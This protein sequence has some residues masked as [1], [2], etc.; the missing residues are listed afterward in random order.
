M[1]CN[2][3]ACALHRNSLS[4][5]PLHPWP[6]KNFMWL[7]IVD[8]HSKWPEVFKFQVGSSGTKQVISSLKHLIASFGIPKQIVTN[9][10]PQFVAKEFKD[11]CN[12]QG[13]FHSLTPPYHPKSNGQAE[14]FIQSFKR[15]VQK[16]LE[17]PGANLQDVV[18]DFLM[19]YRSTE[20][21]TTG[22]SPSKLL[23]GREIR[24]SLDMLVPELPAHQDQTKQLLKRKVQECQERQKKRH[25]RTSHE[26]KPFQLEEA[27][28]VSQ[29]ESKGEGFWKP[30]T[31]LKVLGQRYYM[32]RFLTG[33]TRTVH[34]N[35]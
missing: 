32:V 19:V 17:T 31:I 6:F 10:G 3:D 5:V 28:F 20:H 30:A 23:L 34:M 18:T 22:E 4:T 11:F 33:T 14:R 24:C 2:C 26:R 1:V 16:G 27:V 12:Q 15:V 7:I 13:I 9:N 25:D 8:A 21:D 29:P 35:H